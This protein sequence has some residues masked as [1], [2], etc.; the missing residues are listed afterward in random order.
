VEERVKGVELIVGA[1]IDFQFGPVILLGIGGTG[2]EIYRDVAVRM[3]PLTATDFRSMVRALNG[4]RL[5]D[6][7][8]GAQAVDM[9]ALERTLMN[10]SALTMEM[11]DF[12]ASIDL[13]P[14]I[15]SASACIIADARIMVRPHP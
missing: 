5:L 14:V 1:K 8:R 4:R 7:Y 11:Q 2:V 13:N 15:C 3:A 6:G 10:F 9:Q 12:I